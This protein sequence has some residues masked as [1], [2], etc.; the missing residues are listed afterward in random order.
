MT[1]SWLYRE[2]KKLR[3]KIVRAGLQNELQLQI[4]TSLSAGV[5]V[6]FIRDGVAIWA[7]G[8]DSTGRIEF[9]PSSRSPYTFQYAWM[10]LSNE[11]TEVLVSRRPRRHRP[12]MSIRSRT[13]HYMIIEETVPFHNGEQWGVLRPREMRRPIE[14]SERDWE[15]F[16][17]LMYY[18]ETEAFDRL[19]HGAPSPHDPE[20]WI[21]YDRSPSTQFAQALDWHIRERH[22]S[23]HQARTQM[24]R[25]H[26]LTARHIQLRLADLEG[27]YPE[28]S[29]VR[30]E[31]SS[32]ARDYV[33]SYR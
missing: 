19:F 28:F 2:A 23:F 1:R 22:K 25:D 12:W 9:H 7:A 4:T 5:A 30:A 13:L 14:P 18:A 33:R 29:T 6:I 31:L 16:F 20:S 24:N 8:Q 15:E 17:V 11:L 10:E 26:R 3:R 21:P 27:R 32:A